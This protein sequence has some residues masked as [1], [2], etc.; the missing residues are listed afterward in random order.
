M[1]DV[2]NEPSGGWGGGG[3]NPDKQYKTFETKLL[4]RILKDDGEGIVWRLFNT[5][6]IVPDLAVLGSSD[7]PTAP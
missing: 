3:Q 5:L 6:W 7:A 2:V 1:D 4:K